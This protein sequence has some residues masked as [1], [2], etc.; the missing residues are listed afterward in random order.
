MLGKIFKVIKVL[1]TLCIVALG[2]IQ[3]AIFNIQRAIFKVFKVLLTLCVVALGPVVAGPALPKDKVVRTEDLCDR[4]IIKQT[5][6]LSKNLH[7]PIF[8]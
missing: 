5:W 6:N 8:G 1:L 2:N 3:R 7:D 4:T